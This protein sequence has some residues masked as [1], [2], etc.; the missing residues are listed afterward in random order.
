LNATLQQVQGKE[1]VALRLLTPSV[2]A[3]LETVCLKCLEKE[4]GER[5]QSALELAEELG[6]FLRGEPIQSRPVSAPEKLWRW[7]RRKPALASLGATVIVLLL[8]VTIGSP[9]ALFRINRERERAEQNLYV[10]NVRLANEALAANNLVHGRAL[11]NGI[12]DSPQ[13]RRFRGWEWQHLME[14]CQ[15]ENSVVL[16]T[17]DAYVAAVA[18]APEPDGRT[19]ASLSGD[20]IVNVWNLEARKRELYWTAHANPEKGKPT[21]SN[22]AL[23]FSPDGGTI[24]T[25][26]RDN[27]VRIWEASSGQM[28]AELADL[29]MSCRGLAFSG[30]G[31]ILGAVDF[32]GQVCLWALTNGLPALLHKWAA[33]GLMAQH[34]AFSPDLKFL[35]VSGYEQPATVWDI[36][37]PQQPQPDRTLDGTQWTAAFSPDGKWLLAAGS[38]GHDLRRWELPGWTEQPRWPA[39]SANLNALAFSAD[40]RFVASGYA[41]G[42]ITLWDVSG[43]Q[44]PAPLLGHEDYVTSLAFSRDGRMLVSSSRDQ[45]VRLWDLS[46][47]DRYD[48][49]GPGFATLAVCFSADSRYLA[50]VEF[51]RTDQLGAART[52]HSV[53]LWEVTVAGLR[54]LT[55][56]AVGGRAFNCYPAF[57]PDGTVLA[58]DDWRKGIQL[59]AVPSL[60]PIDQLPSPAFA[61]MFPRDGRS[62]LYAEGARLALHNL[63]ASNATNVIVGEL[64]GPIDRL[65]L[66]PDGRTAASTTGED[67][68]P[69]VQLWD[70]VNERL[71]GPLL[72]HEARIYGLAFSP[73]GRW[74]ASTS[75]D[76]KVGIWNVTERTLH[77]FLHGHSGVLQSASFSADGRRLAAAGE[78]GVV[79]LW[80]TATWQEVAAFHAHASL[81]YVAFSPDGHWLAAAAQD[82]TIRLWHAPAI[83]E[84]EGMTEL[85]RRR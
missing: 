7:C 5:F 85:A 27:T 36:S 11:L 32:A 59:F 80:D 12:A 62:M 54:G 66:S 18:L 10:A 81:N 49:I 73:D 72:G 60:A 13:Q 19:A 2:P 55:N 79:R 74:L 44:P 48:V 58:V 8:A 46:R 51:V 3:D 47:K 20:G 21:F 33:G 30:D 69:G 82:G 71:L 29:S 75:T 52:G 78:D 50:S 17:H 24:A 68:S 67:G 9:V 28:I 45:T 42:E 70:V 63:S 64:T 22:L 26:G 83:A 1:P 56:N 16:G 84:I 15:N 23:V 65:T 53:T 37:N 4:P 57:S 25:G 34:I 35:V 76:T 43:W 77:Q 38:S 6:R 31:R 39:R 41:N 40:S 61:P 14:R